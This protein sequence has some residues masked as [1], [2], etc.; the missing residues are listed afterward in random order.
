MVANL[1]QADLD[2]CVAQARRFTLQGKLPDYI[3]QLA[4]VDPRLLTVYTIANQSL[5][6]GDFA[7]LIDTLRAMFEQSVAQVV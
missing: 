4:Q 5:I 6:S 1:T 3:P 2:A 7:E